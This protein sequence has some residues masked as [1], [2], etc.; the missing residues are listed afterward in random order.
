[1]NTQNYYEEKEAIKRFRWGMED[2]IGK[3]MWRAMDDV[4]KVIEAAMPQIKEIVKRE[5]AALKAF[6]ESAPFDDPELKGELYRSLDDLANTMEA[7]IIAGMR[8]AVRKAF[9]TLKDDV[10]EKTNM[11]LEGLDLLIV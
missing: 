8:R 7:F 6:V 1:M 3:A 5:A 11:A 2:E 4:Q 9:E 10:D